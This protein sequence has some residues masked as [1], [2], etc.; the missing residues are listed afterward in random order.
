MPRKLTR[1]GVLLTLTALAILAG[2]AAPVTKR[3]AIDP[4]ARAR[5]E[6]IQQ[7][8]ALQ[9]MMRLEIRLQ[10]VGYGVLKGAASECGER[11]RP[12]LGFMAPRREDVKADRRDVLARALNLTSLP[13]VVAVFKGSAAEAA[14]LQEGDLFRETNSAAFPKPNETPEMALRRLN[15][16][17]TV[18]VERNGTPVTLTMT[19]DTVC[20]YPLEISPMGEVNAFADGNQIVVS[21]GML[22][23]AADDRELAL[24]IG[25]ELGHNVMGHLTKKKTNTILGAVF[26]IAAAA[27]GVNTQGTFSKTGAQAY[28]QDFEAEADYVGLYYL[29]RAGYDPQGAATFWRRMATEHP[30]SIRNNHAASHPATPE[31]FLALEHAA[32]EITTK[33]TS[34][35][36]LVPPR[37][38]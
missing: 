8:L 15:G 33:L 22:R 23:F 25:H 32:G 19:P 6:Q 21:R 18:T 11:V 2:C 36:E 10:R 38:P 35:E 34:G 17:V 31:R 4:A 29:A 13:R 24:V 12:A 27:Y 14:G 7:E 30:G 20:S 5:E 37:K 3:V 26:D 9:E 1:P 28:S 16:P